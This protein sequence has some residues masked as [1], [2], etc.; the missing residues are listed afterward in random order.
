MFYKKQEIRFLIKFL[1][2]VESLISSLNM[3]N[4]CKS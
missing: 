2:L 1:E 4:A 3:K